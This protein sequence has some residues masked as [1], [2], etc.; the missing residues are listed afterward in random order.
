MPKLYDCETGWDVGEN[1][2]A[3]D[4]QSV[5]NAE[6]DCSPGQSLDDRLSQGVEHESLASSKVSPKE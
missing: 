4:T 5:T 3:T 2:F 6:Q 1:G